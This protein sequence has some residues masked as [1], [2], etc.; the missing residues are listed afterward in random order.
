LLIEI[1]REVLTKKAIIVIKLV[2]ESKSKSN[3]ELE[4][5]IHS[6]LSKLPQKIPWMESI[7][8]VTV[9]EKN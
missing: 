3:R 2:E 7:E 1:R 4:R 5:E 8:K 9:V 6:E